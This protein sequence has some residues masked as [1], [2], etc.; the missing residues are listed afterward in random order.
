MSTVS[1]CVHIDNIDFDR[2]MKWSLV[3]C[4][5]LPEGAFTTFFWLIM[6]SC[7]GLILILI[8][9]NLAYAVPRVSF[10]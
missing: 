8:A 9:M 2:A 3:S 4:I 10:I 6:N 5:W 7:K 1:F